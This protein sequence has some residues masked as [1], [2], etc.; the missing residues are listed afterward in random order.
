MNLGEKQ[1]RSNMKHIQNFPEYNE[2]FLSKAAAMGKAEDW[3]KTLG[4]WLL[5]KKF[6]VFNPRRKD[7]D[8]T[9]TQCVLGSFNKQRKKPI[10]VFTE[11]TINI[12]NRFVQ[13]LQNKIDEY[14][15]KKSEMELTKSGLLD[16]GDFFDIKGSYDTDAE[17]NVY[18]D[19]YKEIERGAEKKK[20]E[21]PKAEIGKGG[22]TGEKA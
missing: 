14:F 13:S 18:P 8:S 4:D 11:A 17:G 1:K 7:W 22:F 2:G 6:N 15:N 21:G 19:V 9:W 20:K 3:Q 12:F 16:F 10:G 5:E